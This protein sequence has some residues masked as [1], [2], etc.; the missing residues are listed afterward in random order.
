MDVT[1]G[2]MC[3]ETI[4]KKVLED[5][6][7]YGYILD[8]M[9]SLVCSSEYL[10]MWRQYIIAQRDIELASIRTLRQDLE[11]REAELV[12]EQ[13]HARSTLCLAKPPEGN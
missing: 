3:M 6:C 13:Q 9:F 12:L 8:P 2:I 4:E 1:I 5:L 10:S 7:F 11:D